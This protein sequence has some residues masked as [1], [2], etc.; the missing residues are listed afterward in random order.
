MDYKVIE[1]EMINEKLYY[2]EYENGLKAYVMCKPGYTKKYAIFATHYGSI[3]SKFIAS[4]QKN[5]T[6]VPDGIAHFLEHKLFEQ[7]DGSVMDKFSALGSSPNAYTSFD[8]TAYLFMCTDKFDENFKLLLDYVQKP[9]LTDENVEKE[10]GIIGQEIRM[11]E[12]SANW[13]VFFNLLNGLYVNNPVKKDIAGTIE[14]I[15]KITKENLYT[16]YNTFYNLSNMM[17]FAIGDIN[18]ENTFKIIEQEVNTKGPKKE[19][20]RIYNDEPD[21]INQNKVEKKLQVS[22]PLFMIGFKDNISN[23]SPN[24]LVLRDVA[25]QIALEIIAG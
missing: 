22:M 13:Q 5:P 17:I 3:D 9:Y 16:C 15:A 7:E 25:M 12:D 23:L 1:N 21:K 20:T 24:D 14:S 4:E 6:Q 18:P 2:K 10:K 19:V 11:Y 8:H